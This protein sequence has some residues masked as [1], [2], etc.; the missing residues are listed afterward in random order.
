MLFAGEF[1]SPAGTRSVVSQFPW[2][3]WGLIGRRNR[4]GK[5]AALFAKTTGNNIEVLEAQTSSRKL[6]A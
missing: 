4:I 5:D 2:R 3:A 1:E 6:E